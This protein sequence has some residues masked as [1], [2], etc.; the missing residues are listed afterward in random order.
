MRRSSM[1]RRK[2]ILSVMNRPIHVAF[3]GASVTEQSVHH[4]TGE[5][6]G[7]VNAFDDTFASIRNIRTSRVSAGSSDVM[8]AGV[9]YVE[10]VAALGPD[11]C[12]LDWV[13]PSLQDCDPRIVQQIYYR[14]ME[15]DILPVTILFPRT[16][17]RQKD[18]PIAREMARISTEFGFPYFDAMDMLGDEPL[19]GLLRDTVHTTAHGALVYAGI[20]DR[21]L[22]QVKLPEAPLPKPKAPFFV[23]KA[24][25]ESASPNAVRK[26]QLD[27]RK[28]EKGPLGLC[29]V[30]E[31]RVGPYSPVI[32]VS[33]Q[34][35]DGEREVLEVYSV[36]DAWCHRERQCTKRITNWLTAEDLRSLTGTVRNETPKLVNQVRSKPMPPRA[37][38]LRPRG[39]LYVVADREISCTVVWS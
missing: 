7:Y 15:H 39:D 18:I 1:D 32:N 3:F 34:R 30:L 36:F 16:D 9:V 10:K 22:S 19:E 6:T 8:D 35:A 23:V 20:V 27:V 33:T 11:I 37:R 26:F 5:R 29:L 17:R 24:T 12:I 25:A 21:I 28:A 13:T 31:Q 14:L 38:H 4:A 2:D